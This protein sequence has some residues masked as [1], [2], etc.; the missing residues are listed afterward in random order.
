MKL[1][2]HLKAITT[3]IFTS[4]LALFLNAFLTNLF[5]YYVQG[6]TYFTE[7]AIINFVI[8]PI[9]LSVHTS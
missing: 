8:N 6:I 2:G 9:F 5:S 7:H 1:K 3:V 4:F